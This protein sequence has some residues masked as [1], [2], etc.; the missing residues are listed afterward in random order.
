MAW[1]SQSTAAASDVT[2]VWT[3]I[4]SAITLAPGEV[5]HE[6]VEANFVNSPTDDG[7]F[8]VLASN[9]DSDA[10]YDV[11][12]LLHGTLDNGNDPN[13]ISFSLAGIKRY[14]VQVEATGS[15]DTINFIRR[16]A[17]DNVNL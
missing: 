6:Q 16:W 2:N 17:G 14:K 3:D 9:A 4:G 10:N 13:A 7:E 12:P 11:T 15:T 5:F 1:D 8:R